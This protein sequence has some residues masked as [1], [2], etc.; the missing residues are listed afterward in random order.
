MKANSDMQTIK[1][2]NLHVQFPI[3]SAFLRREIGAIRAVDGV[4]FEIPAGSTVGLV[5]ESGSGKSTTG[6]AL[7]G[8]APATSG[9]VNIF[10]REL[11]DLK[12]ERGALPRT[13]QLVF[14]DPY[15]SL[16][17][18]MTIGATLREAL[19][20]HGIASKADCGGIV[21][22]LLDSVGLRPEL[23]ARYPLELSGGQRQR[24]AIARALAVQP[25]FIVLDEVVSALDVS[26]QGQILNLLMDLQKK[27]GL[28]YLFITHDL[29]V[30]RHVSNQVVVLY[31]GKVMEIAS[32]DRLFA[33]PH[34]PYTHALLSAVPVPNPQIER[35]RAPVE[36]RAEPP[37]PLAPLDGCRFQKS[38]QF[39][40]DECRSIEPKL[41]EV[42]KGHLAACHH[43]QSDAVRGALGA[44]IQGVTA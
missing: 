21:R 9:T 28:T 39:A 43:M 1:V 14:Q 26:I 41:R 23:A 22:E 3:R 30:V 40:T 35:N 31:G 18:R 42:E 7:L 34:H 44:G 11:D 37:N 24:V 6:R 32:R 8:L 13:G 33:A 20:Y 2:D 16:N 25:Q 36:M 17:P 4:S 15:A 27:R 5:G 29:S 38:C 12:G 10:G 19:V